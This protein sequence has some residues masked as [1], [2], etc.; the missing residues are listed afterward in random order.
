MLIGFS[1]M[2]YSRNRRVAAA[3]LI[4]GSFHVSPV[5]GAD[6]DWRLSVATYSWLPWISGDLGVGRRDLDVDVNPGDVLEALDWSTLPVWMSY[7]ELKSGR[8][9]LFNDIIWT[10]LEGSAGFEGRGPLGLEVSA[11]VDYTQLT[12]E[13]GAA[14]TMW[15]N[16]IAEQPG[17]MNVDVL[18]GV[19]YWRQ[20]VEIAADIGGLGVEK[21]GVVDWVDPIVGARVGFGVAPGQSILLRGDIGGFGIGSDFSWQTIATFNA[22]ICDGVGYAIDGYV[23]YRALA[24]DYNQGSGLRRYEMDAVQHGPVLGLNMR[25]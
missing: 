23:G 1:I 22:H 14:Y 7:T 12:T 2:I 3:A 9:T 4:A 16:G 11:D 21:S 24:I 25:F 15:S 19:R 18:A 13:F 17:A 5:L 10:A 20:D 6:V 8:L